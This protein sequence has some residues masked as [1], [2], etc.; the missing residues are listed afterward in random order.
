MTV[1]CPAK[2][3]LIVP[4]K[5]H[6]NIHVLSTAGILRTKI[7]GLPG[8]QGPVMAGAHEAGAPA[9]AITAGLPRLLHMLKPGTLAGVKSI[10]FAIGLPQPVT[11]GGATIKLHG[12]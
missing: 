9:L 7:A 2:S 3:T 10:I 5:A 8:V 11:A 12:D 6:V 1:D 4:P